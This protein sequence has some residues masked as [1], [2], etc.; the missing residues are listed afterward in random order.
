M[1]KTKTTIER[2]FTVAEV[3]D[4]LGLPVDAEII[5]CDQ[6]GCR[7]EVIYG[8]DDGHVVAV[9]TTTTEEG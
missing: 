8:D 1:P 7:T 5:L 6:D 4:V 3:R 9:Y 2:T